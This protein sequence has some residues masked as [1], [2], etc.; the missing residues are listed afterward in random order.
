MI[1]AHR[2]LSFTVSAGHGNVFDCCKPAKLRGHSS[3]F[4]ILH[5]LAG[6][7]VFITD[8]IIVSLPANTAHTLLHRDCHQS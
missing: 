3:I 8:G 1:E 4:F 2:S 7:I 5:A 6:A